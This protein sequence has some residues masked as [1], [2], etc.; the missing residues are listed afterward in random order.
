MS[1]V[2]AV[3]IP[4]KVTHEYI[5]LHKNQIIMGCMVNAAF[6]TRLCGRIWSKWMLQRVRHSFWSNSSTQP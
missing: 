5:I 4:K 1:R 2:F 3:Q 6:F